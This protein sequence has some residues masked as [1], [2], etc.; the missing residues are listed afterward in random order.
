MRIT[1]SLLFLILGGAAASAAPQLSSEA[2]LRTEFPFYGA[3]LAE[4]FAPDDKAPLVGLYIGKGTWDTG[5]EHLKMFLQQNRM[6]YRSFTAAQVLS[7][8]MGS[9]GIRVLIVPGGESWEYLAELGDAGA[10]LIKK[11]VAGGG[12][13][14]GIC[15]GAF[16]ATSYREGGY[17]TGPYGIGLLEGTAYDGTALKTPPFTEGMM[18]FDLLPHFLT[19]GLQSTLRIVLL[20][21]PSFHY[22][23]DEAKEKQINVASRFQDINEPAMITFRYGKGP[24]FLAGPHFE[25]EE[26][27][28]DWG[29]DFNDP[30]SDWPLLARVLDFL[31][32]PLS[33][34]L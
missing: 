11:F 4:S 26:G 13:Y 18:D 25:I 31:K 17:A 32:Q 9:S 33:T 12:G 8:Q 6:S 7:G 16:Y 23:S 21:G 30:E 14:L 5:K 27:L 24:V 19:G 3:E 34:D 15:A 29:A 1:H 22:S 2:R 20:G 28:T 10:L